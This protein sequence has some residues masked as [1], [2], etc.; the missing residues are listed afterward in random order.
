MNFYEELSV[1][2]ILETEMQH[3]VESQYFYDDQPGRKPTGNYIEGN[4]KEIALQ[5]LW[6]E[7]NAPRNDHTYP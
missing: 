3:D 1:L 2:M 6:E 5:I 7:C 4:C